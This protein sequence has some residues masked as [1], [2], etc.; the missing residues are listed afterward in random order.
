MRR[1]GVLAPSTLAKEE[2]TLKPFFDQMRQLGWVEGQNIAYDR[3]YADDQ[4]QLLPGLAAEMALRKPELIYAPPAPAAVAAKQATD[5]IPIVFGAVW[6][7]V[8]TGRVA[9]LARPAAQRQQCRQRRT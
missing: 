7:P 3:A 1:V 9:S 6:D 5:T 2:V 8:A 4:Q